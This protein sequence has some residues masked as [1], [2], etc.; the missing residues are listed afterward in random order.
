MK[1]SA[2]NQFA[3]TATEIR[4]GATT[5]QVRIEVAPGLVFTTSIT[6]EA[7]EELGLTVGRRATAVVRASDAMVGTEG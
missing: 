5:T 7:V 1:L 3:G 2:R 4:E 6:N